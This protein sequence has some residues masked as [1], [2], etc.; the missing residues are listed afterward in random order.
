MPLAVEAFRS[1]ESHSLHAALRSVRAL[2]VLLIALS[3]AA[4]A[5]SCCRSASSSAARRLTRPDIIVCFAAARV[6]CIRAMKPAA[7]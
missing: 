2:C 7:S 5:T 4:A 3:Y 1:K 6:G